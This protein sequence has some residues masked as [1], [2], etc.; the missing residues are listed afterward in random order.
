MVLY[1]AI[2]GS[3]RKPGTA[4]TERYADLKPQYRH[5]D[6]ARDRRAH[7][8]RDR[9]QRRRDPRGWDGDHDQVNPFVNLAM[10]EWVSG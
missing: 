10:G 4:V 2:V 6:A 7:H 5:A 1:G 3:E 9:V 8:R